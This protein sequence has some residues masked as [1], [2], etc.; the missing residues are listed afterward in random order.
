M[1]MANTKITKRE[2]ITMMLNEEV[3]NSN[4]TY[5]AYLTHELELLNNKAASRKSGKPTKTQEMNEELK[6][7]VL[8]VCDA[9]GATITELQNK[10]EQLK[11]YSNQKLTAIVKMLEADGLVVRYK[12]GR[13]TLVKLV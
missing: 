4:E 12:E 8:N 5:V 1:I 6:G 13:K 2:V 11:A 3:I 7:I 10:D 9:E